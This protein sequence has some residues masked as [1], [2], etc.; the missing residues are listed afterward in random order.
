ME[1]P[2]VNRFVTQSKK[3]HTSCLVFWR[4]ALFVLGH[5]NSINNVYLATVAPEDVLQKPFHA[6]NCTASVIGPYWFED[7]NERHL[8]VNTM[9]YVAVLKKIWASL[10]RRKE[11]EQWLNATIFYLWG[12]LKDKVCQNNPPKIGELKAAIRAKIRDIPKEEYIQAFDNLVRR[13]QVC[14]QRCGAHLEHILERKWFLCKA[15]KINWNFWGWSYTGWSLNPP[16]VLKL[17]GNL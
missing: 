14:L 8:T 4:S 3:I 2:C 1:K 7:K 5:V 6:A 13:L 16:K 10:G 12:Y 9:Y 17:T 11:V 15:K